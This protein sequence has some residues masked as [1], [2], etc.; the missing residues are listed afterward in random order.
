MEWLF[1]Y[2]LIA[3]INF[4]FCL[5][6]SANYL[7]FND[8][9]YIWSFITPFIYLFYP[10][11]LLLDIVGIHVGL[12]GLLSLYL[13]LLYAFTAYKVFAD[14]PQNHMYQILKKIS[15][16]AHTYFLWLLTIDF[17]IYIICLISKFALGLCSEL[18]CI[19]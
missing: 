7:Y 17:I 14:T 9:C 16:F 11:I 13:L 19:C 3:I 4:A 15:Y 8:S 6:M 1:F 12:W 18:T 2:S 10:I 5:L